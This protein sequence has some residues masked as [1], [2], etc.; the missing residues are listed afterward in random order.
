MAGNHQS[1]QPP[2]AGKP[3]KQQQHAALRSQGR[4]FKCHKKGHVAKK[5]TYGRASTSRLAELP[6][7]LLELICSFLV[8]VEGVTRFARFMMTLRLTCR[9]VNAKTYDFFGK[10]AFGSLMIH[11]SYRGLSRLEALSQCPSLAAKVERIVLSTYDQTVDQEEYKAAQERATSDSYSRHQ[12]REAEGKLWRANAEQN[13]KAFVERSATD[14]IKL[15]RAFMKLSNIREILISCVD[16]REDRLSVRQIQSGKGPTTTRI[17]AM[18]SGSHGGLAFLRETEDFFDDFELIKGPFKYNSDA[19]EWEGVQQK[20]GL[21]CNDLA[22]ST[23]PYHPE[24]SF[25][26]YRWVR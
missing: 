4:C 21:L 9:A 10:V 18:E 12:R 15:T 3:S 5:C 8:D 25:G 6:V 14:G 23:R 2:H 7:E 20:I 11:L 17:F 26:G 16:Q 24:Y 22:L 19:E 1:V 13:D